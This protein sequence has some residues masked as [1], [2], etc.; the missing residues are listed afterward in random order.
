MVLSKIGGG[1]KTSAESH[2]KAAREYARRKRAEDREAINLKQRKAYAANPEKYRKYQREWAKAHYDENKDK[3]NKRRRERRKA[4]G[5][6]KRNRDEIVPRDHAEEMRVWRAANPNKA[7]ALRHRY[8]ARRRG[9]GGSYTTD[10][11]KRLFEAQNGKCFYCGELIFSSFD[12]ELHVDHKI[13][14]IRG[15]TNDISNIALAC[16]KCNLAKH[17]KTAEEFSIKEA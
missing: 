13:P 17:T 1:D 12:K 2:R 5:T 3:L 15:G 8:K 9:N 16:S 10:E 4:N 14:L 6:T 11:L 7:R